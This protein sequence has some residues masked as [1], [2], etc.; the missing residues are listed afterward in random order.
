VAAVKWLLDKGAA[1]GQRDDNGMNT[2]H[3]AVQNG[4]KDILELLLSSNIKKK[5][6]K[7]LLSIDSKYLCNEGIYL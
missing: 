3:Y 6:H 2:V 7:Y 5:K 4:H 1:V